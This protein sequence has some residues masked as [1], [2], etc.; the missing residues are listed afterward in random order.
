MVT[1]APLP[2]LSGRLTVDREQFFDAL[3][4]EPARP[5]PA[6]GVIRST[7]KLTYDADQ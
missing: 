1:A 3:R 2:L 7:V 6:C 4:R 5:K